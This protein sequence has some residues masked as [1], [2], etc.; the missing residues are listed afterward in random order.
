ME[1]DRP[2]F[3]PLS[4]RHVGHRLRFFLALHT[5]MALLDFLQFSSTLSIF[6]KSSE[7]GILSCNIDE[8]SDA[9]QTNQYMH[10]ED[11]LAPTRGE[12]SEEINA[13]CLDI[14]G[15]WA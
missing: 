4:V 6:V 8:K 11:K 14:S 9:T 15:S 13:F 3:R 1:G 7:Q 10:T 12:R 2:P 5:D